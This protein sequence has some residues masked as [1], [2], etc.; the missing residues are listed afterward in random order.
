MLVD[1]ALIG[2]LLRTILSNRIV[3]LAS[4]H[5]RDLKAKIA[6]HSKYG[7]SCRFAP[8]S[9]GFATTAADGYVYLWDCDNITK[10]SQ[11]LSVDEDAAKTISTSP[12]LKVTEDTFSSCCL[13]QSSDG[14]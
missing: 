10:P 6:A 1:D 8:D 13:L 7:L 14:N 4:L 3:F 11:M 9:R 5:F 12:S 2:I